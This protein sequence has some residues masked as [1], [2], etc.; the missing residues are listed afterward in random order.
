L[1]NVDRALR[2]GH[3]VPT[4]VHRVEKNRHAP[5]DFTPQFGRQRYVTAEGLSTAPDLRPALPFATRRIGQRLFEKTERVRDLGKEVAEIARKA[6]AGAAIAF[7]VT[8]GHS[9]REHRLDR[10]HQRLGLV[11]PREPCFMQQ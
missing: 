10:E 11:R 6:V 5:V 1:P 4:H 3:R 8:T 2:N 7:S 9:R